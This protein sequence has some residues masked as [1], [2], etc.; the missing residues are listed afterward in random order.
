MFTCG[1]GPKWAVVGECSRGDMLAKAVVCGREWCR[2]CGEKDSVAHKRRV[3]RWLP[4]ALQMDRMGYFVFTMPPAIRDGYRGRHEL[5]RV[6][7]SMT[8][9][10]KRNG[11]DRGLRRWHTFGDRP[12]DG[13]PLFNP[14]LNVLVDAG[15]LEPGKLESVKRGWRKILGIHCRCGDPGLACRCVDMYYQWT[16]VAAEKMHRVKY[17]T[18]ATFTDV[19]WDEKLAVAL[20][21]WR[22]CQTWGG[23][24][25]EP[26]WD[27]PEGTAPSQAVQAVVSGVCPVDGCAVS[28]LSSD[29]TGKTVLIERRSLRPP[30]WDEIGA[31]YWIGRG[32]DEHSSGAEPGGWPAG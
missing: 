9:L 1:D 26:V 18:R 15:H 20:I 5:A 27:A 16:D 12:T 8:G 14:H 22:S 6:G 23:W 28:W 13:V 11:F 3:A 24:D 7:R 31:G 32:V 19:N 2:T 30:A 25:G 10:M 17:L 21:G 4:K 29:L